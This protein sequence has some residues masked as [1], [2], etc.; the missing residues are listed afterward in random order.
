MSALDGLSLRRLSAAELLRIRREVNAMELTDEPERCLMGNAM[1]LA[2]CCVAEDGAAAFESG[3]AVL[4]TLTAPE[5]ER[6]LRRLRS[7]EGESARP[8]EHAIESAGNGS[9]DEARF[10]RLKEGDGWTM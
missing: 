1:V 2:H 9:F 6:L 7:G 4:E 5:M 3:Q 10:L 8:A